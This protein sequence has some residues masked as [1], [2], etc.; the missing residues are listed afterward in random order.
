M[1]TL[2]QLKVLNVL[3]WIPVVNF[4]AVVSYMWDKLRRQ[5]VF[6]FKQLIFSSLR[7]ILLCGAY[8]ALSYW[9][10][11]GLFNMIPEPYGALAGITNALCFL[12][13]LVRFYYLDIKKAYEKQDNTEVKMAKCPSC[14]YEQPAKRTVCWNCG[15]EISLE[16]D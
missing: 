9:V 16:V 13:V 3:S 5:K 6:T 8:S 15:A 4:F 2:K 1:I 11:D 14:N 12:I 7:T 10:L